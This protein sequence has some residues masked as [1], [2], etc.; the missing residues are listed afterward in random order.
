MD[1]DIQ[2]IES[3]AIFLKQL[4]TFIRPLENNTYGIYVSVG[5]KLLNRLCLGFSRLREDKFRHVADTS[6][7]LPPCFLEI[8]D[9][10]H[11]KLCCQNNLSFHIILMN[12]LNNINNAIASLSSNDLLRA[13][14][15][16]D[17]TFD[18]KTNCNYLQLSLHFEK[19]F[20]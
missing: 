10:E 3:H 20:F 14:F 9:T 7:P 5:V 18:K 6:K 16:A 11:C 19:S 12:D 15:Y 13:I 2:N 4:S 17:K 1:S 8:K